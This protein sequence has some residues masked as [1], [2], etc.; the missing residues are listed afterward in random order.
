MSNILI[1]AGFILLS[2]AWKVLY[3][4]QRSHWLATT[5][6][7]ARIRH[8]Q[9]VAFVAIMFGF[10]LQWPTLVTLFMF[11]VLVFMY[12]H[13]ARNEEADML[14]QFG[15]DYKRYSEK[16][17]RFIPHFGRDRDGLRTN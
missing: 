2:S 13:L 7:Y 5:G 6:A 8:P 11:P 9:Y 10:L 4:A 12:A 1:V 3:H 17:P 14:A 15:E 16:T